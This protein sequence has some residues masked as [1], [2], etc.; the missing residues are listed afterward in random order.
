MKARC[1]QES[2]IAH[3]PPHVREIWDWLLKECNHSPRKV[4]G[5]T[6]KRGQCVRTYKDIVDGL[7]WKVGYRT[8]RYSKWDC[9]RAMKYLRKHDMIATTK[10]TRG[11]I[12]TILNYDYY[13]NPK[14]YESHNEA[15]MKASMKPQRCDTIN[16]NDNTLNELKTH[17]G[18][19]PTREMISIFTSI[20]KEFRDGTPV[21][22]RGKDGKLCKILYKQCLVDRPSDPLSLWAE[23]IRTLMSEK[24]IATIGGIKGWW[25][26]AVPKK[27]DK[28]KKV[29][30]T[31]A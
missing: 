26:S 9:E 11:M 19:T 23:R 30:D 21:I 24:D 6:I 25:I 27:K 17:T 31:G 7:K 22:D 2:D 8:C 1:I 12:I 16:K 4:S 28:P 5:K 29:I 14:N 15:T 18:K 3:A 10:T 20:Y 13:Q